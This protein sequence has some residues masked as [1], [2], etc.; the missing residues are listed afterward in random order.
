[1]DAY[2]P[3]DAGRAIGR[4]VDDLS[5]WYVRRSRRRFWKG[6]SDS[7]KREAYETLYMALTTLSRLLAPFTPFIAEEIYRNLV[8]SADPDAPES[9]HLADWP[10]AD[11]TAIDESLTA[12]TRLVMRLSSMG[13]AARA[14]A[15]IKVRQPL[16]S[17]V[18]KTRTQDEAGVVQRLSGQLAE[19]LNVKAVETTDDDGSYVTYD[20]K[21]NLAALGPKYGQDLARVRSALDAADPASV[22]RMAESGGPV[23]VGEFEL[24]SDEVLVERHER[25]GYAVDTDAGYMVAVPTQVTREL[26]EEGLAREFVHRLQSLRKT[27]GLDIADRIVTHVEAP[28]ELRRVL[29]KHGEYVRQ[30][31]LSDELLF[32]PA[33]DS[34]YVEE[35]AIEGHTVKMAVLKS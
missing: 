5:N 19:E 10:K 35:Q 15:A 3:T 12:E 17:V 22:A 1:M 7:D 20:V 28:D 9:V 21:P 11:R 30:E 24:T 33:E 13:R 8:P 25:E 34:A 14:R 6:E 26:A 2:N 27:A 31:T 23:K 16:A 29:D 18:V 32:G 4:F